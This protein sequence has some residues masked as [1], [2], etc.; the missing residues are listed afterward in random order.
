MLLCRYSF[1]SHTKNQAKKGAYKHEAN[2]WGEECIIYV[3]AF[4][5]GTQQRALTVV[6]LHCWSCEHSKKSICRAN[7]SKDK[8]K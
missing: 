6:K 5:W 8:M 4:T 7:L 1:S 3:D 2:P